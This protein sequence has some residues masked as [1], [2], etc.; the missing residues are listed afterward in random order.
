MGEKGETLGELVAKSFVPPLPKM[1]QKEI[2]FLPPSSFL[3][4]Y[5]IVSSNVPLHYLQHCLNGY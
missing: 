4:T 1:N 5:Y 3:T 2:K